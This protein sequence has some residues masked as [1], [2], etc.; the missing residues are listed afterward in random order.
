MMLRPVL[1]WLLLLSAPALAQSEGFCIGEA[2]S[3]D[4]ELTLRGGQMSANDRLLAE[5]RLS[6]ARGQ[7]QQDAP[8]AQQDL[9]QLRRDMVQQATRPPALTV[10]PPSG[11]EQ[12]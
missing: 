4:R 5:Q 3:L 1:A 8:R 11:L 12:R 9:E 6:R 10:P 2:R 7:C